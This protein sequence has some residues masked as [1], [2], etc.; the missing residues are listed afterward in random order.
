MTA[1]YLYDYSI[2]GSPGL[3]INLTNKQKLTLKNKIK[4]Q[5]ATFLEPI[6]PHA[7]I[8]MTMDYLVGPW[9]ASVFLEK[10]IAYDVIIT[11]EDKFSQKELFYLRRAEEVIELQWSHK[12]IITSD[13]PENKTQVKDMLNIRKLFKSRFITRNSWAIQNSQQC[14]L[15]FTA[16]SKYF[17]VVKCTKC[18]CNEFHKKT[19]NPTNRAL[20]SFFRKKKRKSD[21]F[22]QYKNRKQKVEMSP[23]IC[24]AATYSACP[25]L[26]YLEDDMPF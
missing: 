26:I 6:H 9:I 15:C 16:D 20:H 7:S 10:N 17:P 1:D 2:I 14:W 19:I 22:Y 13:C 21:V 18:I 8:I 3:L 5:V 4:Q 12:N 25:T 11:S 23:T 24:S